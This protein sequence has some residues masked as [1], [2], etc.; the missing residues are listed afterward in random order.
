MGCFLCGLTYLIDC[1]KSR[2]SLEKRYGD[3]Y[4]TEEVSEKFEIV[5]FL[6]P[7]V[8]VIRRSDNVKGCLM[9]QHN[10]RFYFHFEET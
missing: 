3:V 2:K 9:F 8:S 5:S 6:A 10:P 4:D 1:V 7:F